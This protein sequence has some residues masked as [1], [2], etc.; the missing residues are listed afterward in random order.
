MSMREYKV[1]CENNKPVVARL[2]N[3]VNYKELIKL[4]TAEN[5]KF[6]LW[7]TV[8]GEDETDA[9]EVADHILQTFW[10]KYLRQNAS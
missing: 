9:I 6:I 10:S 8:V 1:I 2:L 5:K 7:L 4:T 3:F